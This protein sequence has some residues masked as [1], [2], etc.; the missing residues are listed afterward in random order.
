ML[1]LENETIRSPDLLQ[2]SLAA[3]LVGGGH[4]VSSALVSMILAAYARFASV[5]NAFE[6]VFCYA[7]NCIL[8]DSAAVSRRPFTERDYQAYKLIEP[9]HY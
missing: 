2:I 5:D 9:L 1:G 7:V 4:I 3:H 8:V 6:L